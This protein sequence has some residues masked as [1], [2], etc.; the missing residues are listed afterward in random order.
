MLDIR[1][2]IFDI[3]LA[4]SNFSGLALQLQLQTHLKT[5]LRGNSSGLALQL[6]LQTYLKT[7]LRGNSSGLALQLQLQTHNIV[8]FS[9]KP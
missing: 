8:Y 4:G 6:Q 9:S 5:L 3:R 1:N 7:L 2:W